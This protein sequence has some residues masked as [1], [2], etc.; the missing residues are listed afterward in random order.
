MSIIDKT[1]IILKKQKKSYFE[2]QYEEKT[3]KTFRLYWLKISFNL[4][5]L[6]LEDCLKILS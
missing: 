2:Q 6:A 4:S 3:K 1:T 5:V